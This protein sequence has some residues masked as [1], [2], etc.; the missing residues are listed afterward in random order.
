MLLEGDK[1][2]IGPGGEGQDIV[3]QVSL[4]L[5]RGQVFGLLG[6]S[7]SGKTLLAYALCGLL[8]PPLRICGGTMV[9][10]CLRM[11]PPMRQPESRCSSRDWER[12]WTS[13]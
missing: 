13:T 5:E 12:Y 4:S 10:K 1:V 6:A 2:S 8:S 9:T 7:G 3:R 11:R